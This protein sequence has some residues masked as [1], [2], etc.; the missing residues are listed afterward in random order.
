M[1]LKDSGQKKKLYDYLQEKKKEVLSPGLT[2]KLTNLIDKQGHARISTYKRTILLWAGSAA[3]IV[4]ILLTVWLGSS[5]TFM[6]KEARYTDTYDDPQLAYLETRKALLIVSEK[7]NEGTQNLQAL[8]KLD[9][10]INSLTP[11]F[12]FGPGIQHLNKLSKFNET[13]ELI[14][15]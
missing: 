1:F 9:Q 5:D 12:S 8:G 7:L 6:R 3:A 11:V 13:I 10:G 14:T 4:V 2:L 15:K